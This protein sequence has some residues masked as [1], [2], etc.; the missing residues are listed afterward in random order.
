MINKK[1]INNNEN[2]LVIRWANNDDLENVNNLYNEYYKLSRTLKQAKW[3]FDN[4]KIYSN[5]KFLAIAEINGEIVGT[6]ALIPITFKKGKKTFLTAKSE[7]TL[8]KRKAYKYNTFSKLYEFIINNIS[9]YDFKFIWGF[10]PQIKAFKRIGFSSPYQTK[11]WIKFIRS[12]ALSYYLS[13]NK[14]YTYLFSLI[15]RVIS[16]Y[17]FIISLIQ[18]LIYKLKFYEKIK[19][20]IKDVKFSSKLFSKY[21]DSINKNNK[22]I[23]ILRNKQFL[24]WRFTQN[25]FIK[26]I[27]IFAFDYSKSKLP[28][29]YVFFGM[30]E[31]RRA[32]IID[33][34][35]KE[36]INEY[37]ISNALM[38]ELEKRAFNMGAHSIYSW[39]PNIYE[40]SLRK[41][42]K[43]KGFIYMNKGSNF[44]FKNISN[45]KK[46]NW[47]TLE[48]SFVFSRL[49][50][51]GSIF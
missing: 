20:E 6:Q 30:N 36:N 18:K 40:S 29:G 1:S 3:I 2:K 38:S 39:D 8:V 46:Y 15:S 21:V 49:M 17:Q 10:T 28:L 43:R 5:E 44:V 51:L 23:F 26:P 47:E 14:N 13:Q 33:F 35:L 42:L 11:S 32:C 25:P 16:Y 22:N 19:I 9:E 37:D 34:S 7:E 12:D 41:C 27:T 24:N 50:N 31:D 48:S 4:S 45:Q